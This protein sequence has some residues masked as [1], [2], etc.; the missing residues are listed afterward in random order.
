MDGLLGF[1]VLSAVF[2][3]V[4]AA[5]KGLIRPL[6]LATLAIATLF[7]APSKMAETVNAVR[8]GEISLALPSLPPPPPVVPPRVSTPTNTV[9]PVPL[10][11]NAPSTRIDTPPPSAST[12]ADKGWNLVDLTAESAL[13]T[14]SGSTRPTPSTTTTPSGSTSNS[15]NN[16]PVSAFW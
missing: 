1:W 13:P 15:S 8:A 11:S 10:D 6:S 16:P 14:V 12:T 2:A 3:V 4:G 9:E 7:I 5:L